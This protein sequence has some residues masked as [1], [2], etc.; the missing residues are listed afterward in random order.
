M[1]QP[2]SPLKYGGNPIRSVASLSRALGI[3]VRD[4]ETLAANANKLYRPAKLIVKADGTTRQPYDALKP[5]KEVHR[6]IQKRLFEKVVF[7][8]YLTGSLK[9]RDANRN[10]ALHAGAA[11]LVTED[12]KNFFPSITAEVVHAV[13]RGFFRFG[14][15]V[16]GLLTQLSIKDG[17]LPQ[18]AIT[19]SYLANLAFWDQEDSLDAYFRSRNI[20]YS[21]YVDDVTI[22]SKGQLSNNELATYIGKIY[23]LMASKK[24]RPKRNKQEIYRGSGPMVATRLVVNKQPALPKLKRQ[25]I[26]AAVFE[27]EQLAKDPETYIACKKRIPSVMG[28]VGHL[29]RLH[30][31]EGIALKKRLSSLRSLLAEGVLEHTSPTAP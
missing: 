7:P 11:T 4:L 28:R 20:S 25:A 18:G 12:I 3:P 1:I 26:R 23:G 19:S 5:L 29:A 15:E 9:G 22:S 16:A 8:P 6:Q 24:L 10:A 30:P 27:L 21:R 31:K 17:A 13:W 14:P 2:T